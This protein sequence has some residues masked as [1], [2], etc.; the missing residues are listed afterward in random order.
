MCGVSSCAAAYVLLA[1]EEATTITEAERLFK[2]AL[3]IGK[4]L[5][6]RLE[7]Q[8]SRKSQTAAF[9]WWNWK[10]VCHFLDGGRSCAFFFALHLRQVV[11]GTCNEFC[12]GF[13]LPSFARL[14]LF[15]MSLV[16]LC[17]LVKVTPTQSKT[18][19]ANTIL[20]HVNTFLEQFF[21]MKISICLVWSHD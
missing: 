16:C 18:C 2:K 9:D 11:L 1:E 21:K 12:F 5:S 7:L 13:F 20:L 8:D 6:R 10:V 15:L 19:A 3:T 14:L 17:H 4:C